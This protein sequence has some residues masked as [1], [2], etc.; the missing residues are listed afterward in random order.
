MNYHVKPSIPCVLPEAP[1]TRLEPKHVLQH[2]SYVQA[3]LLWL[4][5]KNTSKQLPRY[6]VRGKAKVG[7]WPSDFKKTRRKPVNID[8]PGERAGEAD[9]IGR[10]MSWIVERFSVG[11]TNVAG[12]RQ[13]ICHVHILLRGAP[14]YPYIALFVHTPQLNG[15]LVLNDEW[16]M[17]KV[18]YLMFNVWG[19]TTHDNDF[20]FYIWRWMTWRR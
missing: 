14:A 10:E 5:T 15:E 20:F 13:P 6:A 12:I 4:V 7:K 8:R 2:I 18:Q 11:P 17:V 19:L 16:W 9:R 3:S 1:C